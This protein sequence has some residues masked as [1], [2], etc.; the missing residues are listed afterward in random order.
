[1]KK[2]FLFT[3]LLF[4]ANQILSAQE[5][6]SKTASVKNAAENITWAEARE[7]V[8]RENP[9]I[10]T[11]FLTL[12]N[13]ELAYKRALGELA[14]DISF[15]ASAGESL[16]G[17]V[18]KS[19]SYGANASL[20]IFSGFSNV[21]T[22]KQRKAELENAKAKYKRIVSDTAYNLSAAY[23][24]LIWGYE[25]AD[26]LE[27]IKNRRTENKEMIKLRYNSGNVDLGSLKR[28]EADVAMSELNLRKA[29]RYIETASIALL[30]ILGSAEE[31]KILKP[32]EKFPDYRN[33]RFYKPNF[34]KQVEEI[35]E[36]ISAYFE[37]EA[38]Q[39][40]YKNAKSVL[41]PSVNF[42]ASI[43]NSNND[44][45]FDNMQTRTNLSLN[46]S[47]PLFRFSNFIDIKSAYNRMEQA[48]NNLKAV[49]NS[50]FAESVSN[51]H[52]L[53]DAKETLEARKN[54]L[55]A[56]QIQAEISERKYVNG[57]ISYQDWY[58]IE[59]DYINSQIQFLDAKRN[60]ALEEVKWKKFKGDSFEGWDNYFG[61]TL[62]RRISF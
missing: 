58:S 26:L 57:L 28:V 16:N 8:L 15:S 37:N 11:A 5:A 6:G 47:Y 2:L 54:Y 29:Q 61:D 33:R 17:E 4:F 51:F 25:T 55:E 10:K 53:F 40:S 41:Y 14:P 9:N 23:I 31:E 56:S 24:N 44:W 49:K 43:S 62:D 48:Q 22:I 27:K 20:S 35:P 7:I 18:S 46:I 39:Y 1:M 45:A 3:A 42:S 19:L 60:S 38:A 52:S 21:N 59:N 32:G 50:L 13:A 12:Q 36:Y 34:S 30:E